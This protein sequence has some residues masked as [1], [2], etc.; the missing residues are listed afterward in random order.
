MQIKIWKL[1]HLEAAKEAK[2]EKVVNE[3]CQLYL[4]GMVLFVSYSI[5]IIVPENSI[6]KAK[7]NNT[8]KFPFVN[9]LQL[10]S[11]SLL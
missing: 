6:Q 1:L 4:Q 5:F 7:V 3:F 9:P 8:K 11:L 10:K 2:K